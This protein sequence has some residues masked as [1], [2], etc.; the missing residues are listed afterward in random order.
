M[1][2]GNRI[3]PARAR[4]LIDAGKAV[5]L[6]VTSSLVWPMVG[7]FIPGSIRIAP[8]PITAGLR[9]ARPASE[10]LSHFAALPKDKEI[11]AYCT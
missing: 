7:H 10:I 9:Q 2:V 8:E 11:I 3:D 1:I 5:V 6:D 4:A